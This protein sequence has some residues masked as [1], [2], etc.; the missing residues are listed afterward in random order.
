MPPAA[1][2]DRN[3][4]HQRPVA[5]A[6]GDAQERREDHQGGPGGPAPGG[7][8]PRG[9][10]PPVPRSGHGYSSMPA[11]R[12]WYARI[13]D[14]SKPPRPSSDA[15]DSASLAVSA[16][17]IGTPCSRASF[18]TSVMSFSI[19]ARLKATRWNWRS[20]IIGQRNV[21]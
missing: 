8:P 21:I 20:A 19:S 5:D 18:T 10:P 7:R 6:F 14:T 4:G 15:F 2:Q 17:G 1:F 9:A 12:S 3:V 11:S 16:T 13:A